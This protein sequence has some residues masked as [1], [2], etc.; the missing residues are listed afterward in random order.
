MMEL[1]APLFNSVI[2]APSVY[3]RKHIINV[4][5]TV[6][7]TVIVSD[8]GSLSMTYF[9]ITF[10]DTFEVYIQTTSYLNTVTFLGH[11]NTRHSNV[12]HGRRK[13][14]LSQR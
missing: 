9:H 2:N 7:V 14:F 5:V 12:L 1:R 8:T 10:N 3:S 11:H 6:T 13:T 4:L